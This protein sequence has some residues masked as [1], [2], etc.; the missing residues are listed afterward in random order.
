[1]F[2]KV[3]EVEDSREMVKVKSQ[4]DIWFVDTELTR[5]VKSVSFIVAWM[6]SSCSVSLFQLTFIYS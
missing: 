1:M 4:L 5:R 2:S 3:I 6:F